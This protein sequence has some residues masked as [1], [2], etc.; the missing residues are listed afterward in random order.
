MAEAYKR[1]DEAGPDE[2]DRAL[3]AALAKSAAV[4]P[5]AGLEERILVRLRTEQ[6]RVV[7]RAWWPW[8]LAGALAAIVVLSAALASRSGL[9]HPVVATHPGVT[10][11]S[12]STSGTAVPDPHPDPT[13]PRPAS[14]RR[15][16]QR[17]AHPTVAVAANP[18]LDQ[19]PS[20]RPLSEQE[21]MLAG[22]AAQ[23]RDQAVLV[24][25]ARTEALRR[26]REEE[27]R[28]MEPSTAGDSQI[29]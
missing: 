3:D 13:L 17:P 5:R 10:T 25:R 21:E 4:E 22:Y 8:A 2:L 11:E 18:R 28:Q 26:D 14:V 7:D 16:V 27:L 9:S 24:A 19:F 23:F 1:T 6:T 15:T 12:P 20:P 29:R